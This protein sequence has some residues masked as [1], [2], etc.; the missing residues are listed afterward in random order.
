M[1]GEVRHVL[2]NH[3]DGR[4][5]LNSYGLPVIPLVAFYGPHL[6]SGGWVIRCENGLAIRVPWAWMT[7]RLPWGIKGALSFYLALGPRE[8]ARSNEVIH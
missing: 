4:V 6:F 3:C 2:V 5:R 7:I 8:I 1:E